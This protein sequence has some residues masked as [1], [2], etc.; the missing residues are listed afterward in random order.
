MRLPLYRNIPVCLMFCLSI[1]LTAFAAQAQGELEYEFDTHN[2][3]YI[4]EGTQAS[5]KF[6]V[7]NKG[8]KPVQLLQVQPECGC[9]LPDWTKT[10]ILPGKIGYIYI[11]YNSTGRPGAFEK[12]ILVRSDATTPTHTLYIKGDVGTDVVKKEFTAE[13]K[14]LSPR[15]AVG[16]TVYNFGKLEKGQKAIANFTIKNTGRQDLIV[17]GVQ[18][19]CNCVSYRMSEPALKPGQTATLELTYTPAVLHDQREVVTVFSNDII[20]PSLRLTLKANVVEHPAP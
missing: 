19:A 3:G 9:T 4:T 11:V 16:G 14:K 6:R 2:F 10:P 15:L 17:R 13:Q 20:M 8:D 12:S 7:R 5:Y 18:S 1:L